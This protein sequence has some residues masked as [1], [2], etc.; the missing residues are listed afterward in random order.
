MCLHEIILSHFVHYILMDLPGDRH[1][2][3]RFVFRGG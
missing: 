1:S 2:V 3:H